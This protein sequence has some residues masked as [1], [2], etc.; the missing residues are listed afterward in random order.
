MPRIKLT[1]RA[2]DAVKPSVGRYTA[3]DSDVSGFG[4]RVA[5]SGERIYVLKY[6]FGGQQR[7]YTIGRHG[8]PW[9]P[10]QARKKAKELLGDVEKGIDPAARRTAD[11]QALTV[12]ELCDLYLDEGATHKKAST[13]KADRGRINHHLKPLLGRKRVDAITRA[14]IERLLVDVASGK[15]AAPEPKKDERPAGGIARGG[16]GVAAQCVTLMGTLLAF[17]VTRGIR[18]D[19]PA[20]GVKKPAVRKME[21]FLSEKEIAGLASA[22]H[23]EAQASGNVYPAAAIKLLLLTGCRRGEILNLQWS[24]VDFERQCLRLPDS[25]TGAKVV[26]LNAPA[27]LLLKALPRIEGNPYVITGGK[28]ARNKK[29]IEGTTNGRLVGIDKVW[30]RVRKKAEL[31]DVRLHDLRHSFASIGAIGGLSLP[32]IGALLGHKHAATTARYSHLSADPIRAANEAVGARIAAAM[33]TQGPTD[34]HDG[35]TVVTLPQRR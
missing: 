24:H 30:F 29:P 9:T 7:W 14:D 31:Q 28:V 21:R 17:A 35:G 19:N 13:T 18:S 2:I 11:R 34:M 33:A 5:P 32:I 26:Y 23:Q 10:E 8:S 4:L 15:T 6:R 20:H 27:L 22:L 12:S 1:K 25:K 3:W 16:T